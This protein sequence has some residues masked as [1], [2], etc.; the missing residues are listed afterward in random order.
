[1]DWFVGYYF[2]N[3]LIAII[4]REAPKKIYGRMHVITV[5]PFAGGKRAHDATMDSRQAG[6][7]VSGQPR[8]TPKKTTDCQL[9]KARLTYVAWT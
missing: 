3:Y 1:M 9:S 8:K 7:A 6:R 2:E 5:R 4:G